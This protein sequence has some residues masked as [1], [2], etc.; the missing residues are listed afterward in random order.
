MISF[1][2]LGFITA[3]RLRGFQLASGGAYLDWSFSL[4]DLKWDP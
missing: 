3:P 2:D 1:S 4:P